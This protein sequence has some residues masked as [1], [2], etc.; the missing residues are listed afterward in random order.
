MKSI[1]RLASRVPMSRPSI[2]AL[3]GVIILASISVLAG[4]VADTRQGAS[5]DLQLLGR[6]GDNRRDLEHLDGSVWVVNRD[7]GELTIFDVRSGTPVRQLAV[8]AGAHDICISES[9]RKAYITAETLN[10]VTTVDTRT[11]AVDSIDVG[12]LPHHIEPSRNGKTIYVSLA[13]HTPGVGEPEYAAIGTRDDSV[14]YVRSSSNLMARSHGPAPSRDGQTVY[15]A[16]DIG[17]E[18]GAVD[19]PT[20][21][22]D[23]LVPSIVRAEEAIT[24]AFGTFLWVSSRGDGTV[25]RIKIGR[26]EVTASIPVGVQ[27]ESLMLTPSERTLV[28]SLRGTPATLAFVD[29]VSLALE[30]TVPIA[31]AGTFGDLAVITPDGR[32]VFATYD[33]GTTGRGGVAVVHVPT[34]RLVQTWPYPGAG[35]PHGVWYSS[36][37]ARF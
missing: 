33:A 20:G 27:P 16:H 28:V 8:G 4:N 34:R 30:G 31:G 15:V 9:A 10:Q 37:Q 7:L 25:K 19:T 24:T 2:A 35:R 32:Y 29:T 36:E 22:I 5:A 13:S 26:N 21:T 14:T 11:L 17:D 3:V 18:L 6:N 23:F 12:P 1:T